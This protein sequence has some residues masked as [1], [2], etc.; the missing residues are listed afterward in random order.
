MSRLDIPLSCD[1]RSGVLPFRLFFRD[2]LEKLGKEYGVDEL[3]D[4]FELQA[5]VLVGHDVSD[6][7]H[8][9]VHVHSE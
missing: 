4:L 6:E 5:S 8:F 1:E 7:D 9:A 2:S 3:L